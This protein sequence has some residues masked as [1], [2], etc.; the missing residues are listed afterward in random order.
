MCSVVFVVCFLFIWVFFGGGSLGME[1]LVEYSP[2]NPF[3]LKV[4]LDIP[5]WI[6]GVTAAFLSCQTERWWRSRAL[7]F[8]WTSQTE[9]F[10]FFFFLTKQSCNVMIPALHFFLTQIY[11]M[12]SSYSTSFSFLFLEEYHQSSLSLNLACITTLL[13]SCYLKWVTFPSPRSSSCKNF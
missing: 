8:Q 5:S 3:L 6:G 13:I 11:R 9:S 10:P 1:Q 2:P 4:H 12:S 7:C